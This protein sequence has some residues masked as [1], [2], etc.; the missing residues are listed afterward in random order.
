[1]LTIACMSLSGGQGKTTTAVLLGKYLSQAG[2]TVLAIDAD[3]QSNLTT[4]LGHDLKSNDPT[5][6]ESIKGDV[7]LEDSIYPCTVDNL[8]LIPSD[9][10]L[11]NVQD[12]LSGSGVGAILLKRRLIPAQE[13]FDI[14]LIDS[15]PQRSQ[16]CK[17][18][19]GAADYILIPCEA[20]VKG[21]GSLVRTLDAVNELREIG[22]SDAEVLGVIPFRDRWVGNN[23]TKESLLCV[24][25]I[26]RE[27]GESLILP[28]IRESERYKQAIS[29]GKTLAELGCHDLEYPFEALFKRIGLLAGGNESE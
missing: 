29:Q 2:R 3:P 22:A 6:L 13:S 24:D 27:V 25:E 5:L 28:S 12:Y 9:D 18:I 23:Q 16:I 19:I 4:F 20:T 17:S 11:D 15:P 7:D 14:C 21:F 1:M 10:G 8:F 26:K